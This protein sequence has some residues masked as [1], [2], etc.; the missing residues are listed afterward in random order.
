MNY[1][2]KQTWTLLFTFLIIFSLY[3]KRVLG[4]YN[5]EGIATFENAH[6]WAKT[7][8]VYIGLSIVLII[9]VMVLFNIILAI[10]TTVKNRIDVEMGTSEEEDIN[11]VFDTVEDE[12]DRL[13]NLKAG[14]IGYTFVGLG[15]VAGLIALT[16]NQ[17]IGIML[18][19]TFLSFMIG[20]ILESIVKIYFYIRGVSHG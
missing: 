20:A 2:V 14:Q 11:D 17:P 6:F 1:K 7:M 16:F 8:L 5:L 12:M 18:N 19:I 15:F 4:I 9:I 3:L 10:G 13:I